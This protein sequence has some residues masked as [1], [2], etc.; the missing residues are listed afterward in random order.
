VVDVV[1]GVGA[2]VVVVDSAVVVASTISL[3]A[4]SAVVVSRTAPVD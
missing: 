3:D 4:A 2:C 1:V